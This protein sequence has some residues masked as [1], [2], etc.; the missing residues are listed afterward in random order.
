MGIV[1]KLCTLHC[2]NVAFA[3]HLSYAVRFLLC[4]ST[5]YPIQS[6]QNPV[7][8]IIII[9]FFFRDRFKAKLVLVAH[10]RCTTH[11]VAERNVNPGLT[12]HDVSYEGWSEQHAGGAH[13]EGLGAR[14]QANH[15]SPFT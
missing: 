1:G 8:C 12:V 10:T 3:S 9:P 11:F 5:P 6:S 13:M 14:V 2:K 15:G 4:A 7:V